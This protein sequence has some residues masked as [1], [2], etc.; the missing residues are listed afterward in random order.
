MAW[1]TTTAQDII[2]D[3]RALIDE[4]VKDG[5]V[6]SS[7]TSYIKT[8][9]A[10]GIRYLNMALREVFKDAKYYDSFPISNKIIPN[11]LGNLSNFDKVDFTGEDKSYPEG[12]IVGAK[13]YYFEVDSDAT[14]YIEE[15]SGTWDILETINVVTDEP[16]R[17]KGKI[18]PTN[19]DYPIR[20]RFSGS[21]F[22]R[23]QNRC[24]FPYN[25][26]NV[27]DY[28]PWI[29]VTLPDNFAEIEEVICEKPVR[30][31]GQD[32]DY[33]IEG[34]NELYI[35]YY[36]EGEIRVVYNTQ[37]TE[38]TAL[39]DLVKLPNPIAREFVNNFVAARS[40]LKFDRDMVNF[41]EDK[42]NELLFKAQAKGPASE[43]NITDSYYGGYNGSYY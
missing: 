18:T 9:E 38:I 3:A 41:F 15:Y 28:R 42:A 34:F 25:F 31:Y 39:T 33:K 21:T 37:V 12:G 26:K 7:D 6:K 8:L 19:P 20:I 2:Y 35:N 4:Y 43:E 10:N 23:H 1:K 13:A 32:S 22:Y 40:A 14:V 29:P 27:P 36:F 17:H 11:L 30:Q 16:S 24:L 5:V